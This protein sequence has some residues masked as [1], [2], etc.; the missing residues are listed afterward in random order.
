MMIDRCGH[1]AIGTN[2]N[3]TRKEVIQILK[4]YGPKYYNYYILNCIPFGFEAQMWA[5]RLKKEH[6]KEEENNNEP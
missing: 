1:E 3:M 2:T 4:K 5:E 6:E